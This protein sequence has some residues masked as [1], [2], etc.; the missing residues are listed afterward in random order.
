M[1]LH[2]NDVQTVVVE[3]K[4][5]F[6]ILE[7]VVWRITSSVQVPSFERGRSKSNLKSSEGKSNS[8]LKSLG[9]RVKSSFLM[10]LKAPEKACVRGHNK[11]ITAFYIN[12]IFGQLWQAHLLKCCFKYWLCGT[13]RKPK[14]ARSWVH[15]WLKMLE[16]HIKKEL[17][18]ILQL[19]LTLKSS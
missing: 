3:H 4:C 17:C 9:D 8:S 2:T 7:S 6:F 11:S 12:Y 15:T 1:Y 19:Q 5:S 10:C 18:E 14:A 13:F 16:A